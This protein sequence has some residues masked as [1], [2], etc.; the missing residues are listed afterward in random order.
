MNIDFIDIFPEIKYLFH[1]LNISI[2]S[3]LIYFVLVVEAIT[4]MAEVVV[5]TPAY[6]KLVLHAAKYPHR[7]V[8]GV[9]LAE[10]PK[11]K[12]VKSVRVVDAVP[13]F[14]QALTLAP[15]ME[16]ALIQV[17]V[18]K[19]RK[20]GFRWKG[21]AGSNLYFYWLL[22]F[23]DRVTSR[24]LIL[25]LFEIEL[26]GGQLHATIKFHNSNYMLFHPHGFAL[27]LYMLN[28]R[29]YFWWRVIMMICDHA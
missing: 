18:A 8:N 24:L 1:F 20:I 9:L 29:S 15:M 6:C 11:N 23:F 21:R 26:C 2:L 14:H 27:T 7:A 25:R 28:C 5:S 4:I 19:N 16:V 22:P 12:D 3:E 17:C 10:K 13:L